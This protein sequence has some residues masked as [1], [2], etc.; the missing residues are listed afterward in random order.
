M[1][2]IF[3]ALALITAGCGSSTSTGTTASL[4]A[5]CA[6]TI[7]K[8]DALTADEVRTCKDVELSQACDDDLT[9]VRIVSV[10]GVEW[11][12]V[13]GKPPTKRGDNDTVL[14][15]DVGAGPSW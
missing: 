10:E 3:A 13:A 7:T 4:Q 8:T 12:L 1:K 15:P 5:A 14:C 2:W 9:V 11:M 6:M